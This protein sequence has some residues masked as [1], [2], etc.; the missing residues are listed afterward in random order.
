M[1]AIT[2]VNKSGKNLSIVSGGRL[3]G[4]IAPGNSFTMVYPL[5]FRIVTSNQTWRYDLQFVAPKILFGPKYQAYFQIEPDGS[6][7]CARPVSHGSFE[8][9]PAQPPGF[10]LHPAT[11]PA[12]KPASSQ[13]SMKEERDSKLPNQKGAESTQRKNL[14]ERRHLAEQALARWWAEF[15]PG[16]ESALGVYKWSLRLMTAGESLENDRVRRLDLRRRHRDLMEKVDDVIKARVAGARSGVSSYLAGDFYRF[17][18][19]CLLLD[20]AEPANEATAQE[21]RLRRVAAALL[22]YYDWWQALGSRKPP[23]HF[24]DAVRWSRRWWNVEMKELGSADDRLKSSELYLERAKELEKMAHDFGEKLD[25]QYLQ[26][27]IHDRLDAQLRVAEI[28]NLK[29]QDAKERLQDLKA[30]VEAAKAA[31]TAAWTELTNGRGRVED[32]YLYSMAWRTAIIEMT[33]TQQA[34]MIASKSHLSRMKELDNFIQPI[35]A[36]GRVSIG[37]SLAT[38]YYRVDAEILLGELGTSD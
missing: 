31:Y 35:Y 36:A 29:G 4:S 24:E 2:L 14:N 3:E 16:R 34:K 1:A 23:F 11:G 17:D 32:L 21:T 25:A 18:A 6:I 8:K 27:A 15:L 9:L 38:K 10:P 26:E 5:E 22:I 28:K 37:D 33:P 20:S 19:N 12:T 30:R 13:K 7:C